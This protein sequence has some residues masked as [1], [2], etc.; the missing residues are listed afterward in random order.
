MKSGAVAAAG[1]LGSF[2][3]LWHPLF[4]IGLVR[5]IGNGIPSAN[6]GAVHAGIAGVDVDLGRFLFAG[7]GPG[8]TG[9]DTGVAPPASAVVDLH[10]AAKPQQ[11]PSM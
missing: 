8:W 10:R 7:Y 5:P 3:G 1:L 6:L 11:R 9:R 4:P 2:S